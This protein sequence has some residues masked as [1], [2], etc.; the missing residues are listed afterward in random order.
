MGRICIGLLVLCFTLIPVGQ[1][2]ARDGLFGP[3]LPFFAG[4]TGRLSA[5]M[6]FQWLIGAPEA[7]QTA[8]LR[9]EMVL[10]LDAVTPPDGGREALSL[11][12]SAK[13]VHW[14]LLTTAAFG[15]DPDRAV[16]A[17]RRADHLIRGCTDRLLRS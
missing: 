9:E 15:T 8:E 10:I 13:R 7:A 16:Q 14:A 17:Q 2:E 3:P 5:L 1:A 12:V 11:R 6:E 4:C